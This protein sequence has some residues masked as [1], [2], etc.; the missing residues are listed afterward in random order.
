VR[1]LADEGVDAAIVARLRS[2]GHDVTYVAELAPG[3]TDDGVLALANS[4][5]RLLL[6]VD[7]DFGELVFRLRRANPGVLLIRLAG[8]VSSQKAD[9]VSEALR[10]H[11]QEMAGAFTV[12]SVRLVRI[13]PSL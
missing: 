3:I 11:G 13:R 9:A 5:E 1:L 7:K 2:D 6:T 10:E 4:E 12:V 8:L